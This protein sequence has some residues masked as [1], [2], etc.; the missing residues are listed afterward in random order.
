M[1]E[2]AKKIQIKKLYEDEHVVVISKPAGLM[3][4]PDGRSKETTVVNWVKR[5]YPEIKDIGEDFVFEEG[6]KTKDI[7]RPGIVHR[8]DKDTSGVLLICKTE[9]GFRKLKAQFKNHL[10]KKIYRAL[11]WGHIKQDTGIID[12]PIARSKSDFRARTVPNPHE[13]D[14]RGVEREAITRYKVLERLYLKN[15]NEKMA[16][17]YVELL[18]LTGRTHQLRVHC[19]AMRHPIIDDDLYGP[20]GKPKLVGRTALHAFKLSFASV[21]KGPQTVECPIPEDFSKGLA[22]LTKV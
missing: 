12:A 17:T 11:V 18:P 15:K 22:K 7:A 20:E 3:V 13:E 19:K 14:S 16:V 21:K 6:G 8:L 9:E 5:N 4:H 1:K 2:V 10:V